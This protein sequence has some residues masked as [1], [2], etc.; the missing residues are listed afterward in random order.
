VDVVEEPGAVVDVVVVVGEMAATIASIADA[1][2]CGGTTPVGTKAIVISMFLVKRTSAGFVAVVAVVAER[3]F[4]WAIS[5]WP[6]FPASFVP[7]GHFMPVVHVVALVPVPLGGT[8]SLLGVTVRPAYPS[9]NSWSV[10]LAPVCAF[11]TGRTWM[12]PSGSAVAPA[13]AAEGFDVSGGLVVPHVEM[14]SAANQVSPTTGAP[15]DE[16]PAGCW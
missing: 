9:T 4:Q 5:T 8:T 16:A 1:G 13:V 3:F 6:T 14:E 15:C 7:F 12:T 2:G 10:A 11:V